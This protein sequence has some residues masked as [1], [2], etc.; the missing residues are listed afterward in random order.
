MSVREVVLYS[1]LAALG[2]YSFCHERAWGRRRLGGLAARERRLALDVRRLR[3]RE[4][5]LRAEARAL[6]TDPYYVERTIREQFGWRPVPGSARVVPP[7]DVPTVGDS[8]GVLARIVPSLRVPQ[9]SATRPP[10]PAPAP[11]PRAP[12]PRPAVDPDRR[13]LASLGYTSVSHFQR[14][15]MRGHATGRIDG[16]TRARARQMAARLQRLG[17]TSVQAFQRAHG[18]T[19]DGI[20]G[21]RTEQAAI[22]E[23]RR[24]RGVMADGGN[25][26]PGNGG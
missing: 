11:T 5:D 8:P 26:L 24:G 19:V 16:A 9:P 10:G 1:V 23:L 4:R 3:Q 13:L 7:I 17:H 21:R 20:Y 18:L 6:R 14:K 15:M 25:A 12:A 2:A 22:R